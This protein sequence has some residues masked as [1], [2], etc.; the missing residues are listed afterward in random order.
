M[1]GCLILSVNGKEPTDKA[2][3]HQGD[4]ASSDLSVLWP[5]KQIISSSYLYHHFDS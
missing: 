1:P 3:N 2:S 4:Q 5:R